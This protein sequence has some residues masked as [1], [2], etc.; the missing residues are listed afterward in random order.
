MA[1]PQAIGGTDRGDGT[2]PETPP[3]SPSSHPWDGF[4]TGPGERAGAWRASLALARGERRGALAAGGARAVGGGQ[5]AAAGGPGGRMAAP[6]TRGRRWRTSRPRRSPRPAPRR[7]A[8]PGRRLGRAAG[9]GSAA[10]TCSCSRTSRAWSGPRW[11]STSWRT[12]S[13]PSTTPA[14]P[15]RSRRGRG[16]ASGRAGWPPR[17]VNRLVGRPGR[18]GRPA[19]AWPR[20]AATCSTAPGP[21]GLALSAEAVE[22]LAEAADGYRTL[23]GWLA[24]LALAG[25]SSRGQAAPSAGPRPGGR[26]RASWP[27][28]RSWPPPA[29]HRRRSPAPSPRGSASGSATSAAPS[30]Q[31]SVVEAAAPGHA[32]GP[33]PHRPELRRHRRLLRRPRPRHRPPRLPGRRRPARRRPRPGGGGDPAGAERGVSPHRSIRRDP[34]GPGRSPLYNA[35]GVGRQAI[36]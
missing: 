5:V 20:A 22:P 34:S 32:P 17:L 28:R 33:R 29:D 15:W 12:R 35:R 10:S 8:G 36:E 18:P 9:A 25:R 11:P 23:D 3:P 30:R 27:R 31:A 26:R 21:A 24:R 6:P 7:P 19:R 14:P 13:T 2:S 4:L 16:P 1:R